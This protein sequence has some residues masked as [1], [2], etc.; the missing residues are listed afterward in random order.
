MLATSRSYL[1]IRIFVRDQGEAESHSAGILCY[2]Y[3]LRRDINADTWRWTPRVGQP[4]GID[5]L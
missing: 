5:K 3:D 2:G 1:K 4:D